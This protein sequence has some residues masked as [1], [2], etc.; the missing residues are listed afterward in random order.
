MPFFPSSPF[1]ADDDRVGWRPRRAFKE[2]EFRLGPGQKKGERRD[3]WQKLE[4]PRHVPRMEAILSLNPACTY[5]RIRSKLRRKES[6]APS[7]REGGLIKMSRSI[8]NQPNPTLIPS[9]Q[10]IM[11]ASRTQNQ[12]H[13]DMSVWRL[14]T[15]SPPHERTN[16]PLH[17][18]CNICETVVFRLSATGVL[19]C[20]C[21]PSVVPR[22]QQKDIETYSSFFS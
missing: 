11:E 14:C 3:R 7:P 15:Q 18:C 12:K 13:M 19:F 9:D 6:G 21:T 20:Q 5:G 22:P 10:I 16:R 17:Y 8:P 4:M 2:S 1:Y